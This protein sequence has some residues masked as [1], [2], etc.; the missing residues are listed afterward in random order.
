MQSLIK[1]IS[2]LISAA[3]VALYPK[4]VTRSGGGQ[5]LLGWLEYAVALML[6][7]CHSSG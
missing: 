1:T 4:K 5:L 7:S 6:I 3:T 2:G